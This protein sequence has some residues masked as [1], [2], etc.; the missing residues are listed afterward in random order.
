MTQSTVN[1]AGMTCGHCVETVT[2]ALTGLPGVSEASVSL[3]ENLARVNY[4]DKAISLFELTKAVE[5]AGF[6]VKGTG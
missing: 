3:E 6:E 1:I 5:G 2:K 4:D